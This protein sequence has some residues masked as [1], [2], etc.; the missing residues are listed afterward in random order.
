M[1]LIRSD[2]SGN[3]DKLYVAV[4]GDLHYGSKNYNE[5]IVDEQ[6][7]FVKQH[8]DNCSILFL[9]DLVECATKASVGRGIYDESANL[10][11]QFKYI[12]SKF[13]PYA[14]LIDGAVQGNHCERIAQYCG[15]DLTETLCNTFGRDVYL[16]YR[17]YVVFSWNKVAYT[18]DIWHGATGGATD[19]GALNALLKM[20]DTAFA[21]VHL[22][23][24]T[25]KKLD[26]VKPIWMPDTRNGK[27][28]LVNSLFVNTGCAMNNGGGYGEMKGY[29]PLDIGLPIIELN[30]VKGQ[31]QSKVIWL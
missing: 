25:H 15:L 21:D 2:Y 29:A 23:G 24:H 12:T 19:G 4:F 5:N 10:N 20:K 7:Y 16:G 17:G 1:R 26:I 11:E 13:K 18:F 31:K 28:V 8:R 27:P 30:G 14:D 9:G 3:A 6:L 22:M